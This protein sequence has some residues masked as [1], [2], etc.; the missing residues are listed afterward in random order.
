MTEQHTEF[1]RILDEALQ[2]GRIASEEVYARLDDPDSAP[3]GSAWLKIPATSE[4]GIWV[5]ENCL[6]DEDDFYPELNESQLWDAWFSGA[7]TDSVAVH[8]AAA[9]AAA[10]VLNQY[11]P[12]AGVSSDSMLD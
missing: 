2:A 1:Q 3:T 4:F 6:D 11:L 10:N 9:Q 12:T 8:E 5:K 7:S